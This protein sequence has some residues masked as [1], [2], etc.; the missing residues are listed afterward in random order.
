MS[1]TYSLSWY[2]PTSTLEVGTLHANVKRVLQDKTNATNAAQLTNLNGLQQEVVDCVREASH[3][4][5]GMKREGQRLIGQFVE[6]LRERIAAAEEQ[7]RIE[8]AKATTPRIMTEQE[9]LQ[10]RREAITE[11][12]RTILIHFCNPVNP[13]DMNNDQ[14]RVDGNRNDDSTDLDGSGNRQMRFLWSFLTYLYSG[15]HP[16][17][18]G[19]GVGASVKTFIEFLR[20]L[21]FHQPGRSPGD[22][23]TMPFTPGAL[24]R[25]AAGQLT[26]ELHNMYTHGTHALFEKVIL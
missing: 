15:N 24:V 25:S 3:L 19:E 1:L 10:A 8:L 5:A 12:K 17:D 6:K 26:V 20:I 4:A 13:K 7:R 9:R 18:R 11:P 22:K 14:A 2:H 16:V 23:A 21:G